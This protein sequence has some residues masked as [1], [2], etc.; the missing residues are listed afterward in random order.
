MN[1]IHRDTRKYII[2]VVESVVEQLV[3]VISLNK[4]NSASWKKIKQNKQK[5]VVI[6]MHIKLQVSRDE[7]VFNV[8][9]DF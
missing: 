2:H 9:R 5:I 4:G 1:R 3:S 6:F 8:C 7:E